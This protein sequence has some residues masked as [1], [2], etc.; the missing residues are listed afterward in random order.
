MGKEAFGTSQR[1]PSV[2]GAVKSSAASNPTAPAIAGTR[3]YADALTKNGNTNM[4]TLGV[5]HLRPRK[6]KRWEKGLPARTQAIVLAIGIW[7][8]TGASS[9][10][11][12]K[13]RQ[14]RRQAP[15]IPI[16]SLRTPATRTIR[17]APPKHPQRIR[18]HMNNAHRRHGDHLAL[19]DDIPARGTA[20]ASPRGIAKQTDNN[21]A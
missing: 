8:A 17:R 2:I 14:L 6:G 5:N 20:G 19:P 1:V 9:F 13:R 3:H 11:I 10:H 18:I 21:N 16:N 12:V 4:E 15:H 7:G